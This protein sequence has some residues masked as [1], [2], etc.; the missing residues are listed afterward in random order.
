MPLFTGT[1][2]KP[3]GGA[4]R[5]FFAKLDAAQAKRSRKRTTPERKAQIVACFRH[6][7]KAERR[8]ARKAI[9]NI[10]ANLRKETIVDLLH[11][12]SWDYDDY[13]IELEFFV[14]VEVPSDFDHHHIVSE[15]IE[16]P[17]INFDDD[18]SFYW[19]CE[20]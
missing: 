16:N 8:E 1:K 7:K 19:D 13:N 10:I 3:Y 20:D 18:L 11:L 14:P 17:Q 15:V 2:M 5:A 6:I 4:E 12:L 9:T